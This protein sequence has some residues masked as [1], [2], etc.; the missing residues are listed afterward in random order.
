MHTLVIT[1]KCGNCIEDQTQEASIFLHA[2]PYL[3]LTPQFLM[4][5]SLGCDSVGLTNEM[6]YFQPQKT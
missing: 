4:S 3:P 5:L 6:I 1:I 2:P